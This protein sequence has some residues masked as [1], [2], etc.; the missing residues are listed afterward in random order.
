V[1]NVITVQERLGHVDTDPDQLETGA[2]P[3]TWN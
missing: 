2:N 1:N 3:T